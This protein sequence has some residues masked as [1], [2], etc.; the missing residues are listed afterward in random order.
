[1]LCALAVALSVLSCVTRRTPIAFV[2]NTSIASAPVRSPA[3][4]RGPVMPALLMSRST[5]P[6]C[7]GH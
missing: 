7:V 3:G 5:R 4:T 2:S 1:M 6:S